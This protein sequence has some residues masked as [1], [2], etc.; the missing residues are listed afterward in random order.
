MSLQELFDKVAVNDELKKS[1]AE[2]AKDKDKLT[3]WLKEQGCDATLEQLGAFIR[4]KRAEL[5][6]DKLENAAGGFGGLV[7]KPITESP[8]I[9]ERLHKLF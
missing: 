3:A 2:A 4:E 5:S 7:L 1:F 9:M 8:E 6:D